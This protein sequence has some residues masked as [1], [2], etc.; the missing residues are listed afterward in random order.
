MHGLLVKN[1]GES[2][3][4]RIKLQKLRNKQY[5]DQNLRYKEWQRRIKKK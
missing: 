2:D 1:R 5:E 4:N 3:G